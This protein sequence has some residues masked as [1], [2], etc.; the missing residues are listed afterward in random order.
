MAGTGDLGIVIAYQHQ[1][2]SNNTSQYFDPSKS[3]SSWNLFPMMLRSYTGGVYNSPQY[4][5]F[6]LTRI[7]GNIYLVYNCELCHPINPV[8]G[9]PASG[10]TSDWGVHDPLH[11]P[12]H[13]APEVGVKLKIYANVGSTWQ[14]YELQIWGPGMFLLGPDSGPNGLNAI[15]LGEAIGFNDEYPPRERDLARPTPFYPEII[16]Y[17]R[18]NA[19]GEYIHEASGELIDPS[20]PNNAITAV[21]GGITY[22]VVV[23]TATQV[24]NG[25]NIKY[26]GESLLRNG[27]NYYNYV[28]NNNGT[29]T[30]S[31][32]P[33]GTNSTNT[34]AATKPFQMKQV[35]IW[36][37]NDV[38]GVY[39]LWDAYG[40]WDITTDA[41]GNLIH[42]QDIYNALV[43]GKGG[44][45]NYFYPGE[46][47]I[48][49]WYQNSLTQPYVKLPN[50]SVNPAAPDYLIIE[51]EFVVIYV[52]PE[53]IITGILSCDPGDFPI[54]EH[55]FKN[56][57][58]I[59]F[60]DQYNVIESVDI[61][62]TAVGSVV[63]VLLEH[64]EE[65]D[66]LPV[67][68]VETFAE[69]VLT[70]T[71][72]GD[73]RVEMNY[74]YYTATPVSPEIPGPNPRQKTDIFR[75][76]DFFVPVFIVVDGCPHRTTRCEQLDAF[77]APS[78]TIMI[79]DPQNRATS[80]Q[81]IAKPP[82]GPNQQ[83][84]Q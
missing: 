3:I 80:F 31:S 18:Q 51:K 11:V 46:Y 37:K 47:K 63:E 5:N 39:E 68:G 17:G 41:N 64:I 6:Y 59:D 38:T 9:A 54:P 33:N 71:T 22:E 20:Y 61:Y 44:I 84:Y 4:N 15:A 48:E 66:L 69:L 53:L 58:E 77:F 8:T 60:I 26:Q 56:Y 67:Y 55:V 34:T 13:D 57:A 45:F 35:R 82:V 19:E 52:E 21:V 78:V 75:I 42:W 83:A 49:G 62:F 70:Y 50:G 30:L 28:I 81:Y 10:I 32:A 40:T 23:V 76:I 72:P 12:P 24:G 65:S 43:V 16:I 73:Y 7:G 29:I 36:R 27:N 79:S 74:I 1:F 25:Q 14:C 2:H